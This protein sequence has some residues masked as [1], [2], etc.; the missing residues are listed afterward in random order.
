MPRHSSAN[1]T[2]RASTTVTICPES[3]DA[4]KCKFLVRIMRIVNGISPINNSAA[5]FTGSAIHR[6]GP[7]SAQSKAQAGMVSSRSFAS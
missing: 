7:P 3:D 2:G 1:G 5:V 6:I 4:D